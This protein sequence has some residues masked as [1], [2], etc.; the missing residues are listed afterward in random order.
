[1]KMLRILLS[2]VVGSASAVYA[3]TGAQSEGAGLLTYC[4]V[5]FFAMIV[6]FQL[7]PAMIL[8]A[9]L[10]KGLFSHQEKTSVK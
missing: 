3:A 1:M 8:F 2:M 9:G 4:F 7:A 10:I 5:G 6:V